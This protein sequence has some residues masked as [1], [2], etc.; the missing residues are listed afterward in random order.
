MMKIL[1]I[2]VYMKTQFMFHATIVGADRLAPNLYRH[3][4]LKTTTIVA[5]WM[6]PNSPNRNKEN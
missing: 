5:S 1:E 3:L 2:F 4:S 6:Q